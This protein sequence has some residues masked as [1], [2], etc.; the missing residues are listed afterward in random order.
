MKA[1]ETN[2][3]GGVSKHLSKPEES[4]FCVMDHSKYKTLLPSDLERILKTQ[5]IVVHGMPWEKMAFDEAGLR[6]LG[7]LDTIRSVQG[8]W[9]MDIERK[10]NPAHKLFGDQSLPAED[11]HSQRVVHGT[12]RQLLDAS[13]DPHGKV[14]NALSIPFFTTRHEDLD[15]AADQ[16]AW[17]STMGTAG[18][19]TLE[20]P[21]TTHI[22]W[23]LAGLKGA[24]S[25]WHLDSDGLGTFIDVRAGEKLWFRA[26]EEVDNFSSVGF[27]MDPLL[28]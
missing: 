15:F 23:G 2:Y 16:A 20:L 8:M 4:T 13:R 7:Q 26:V 22:R 11:D 9:M 18:C 12:I 10:L 24:I 5:D 25:F 21:P 27:F 1:A 3:V 6:S 19:D 17:K 28:I 14:L